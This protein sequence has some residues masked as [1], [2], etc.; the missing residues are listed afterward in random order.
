VDDRHHLVGILTAELLQYKVAETLAAQ[1]WQSETQRAELLENN[2][3]DIQESAQF[4]QT[5]FDTFPL[6]VFWKDRS[7][8]FLGCNQ[9]FARHA[10]LN[11]V[12]EILGQT[13]FDL[14][15][16]ETEAAAYRADDR[17]VI[18]SGIAKL[19]IIEI[20]TQADGTSIWIETNKLPL[21]N[22]QGETIGV[23]GTYQDITTRKHTETELQKLSER[24][25]LSLKSAAAGCWEW[26]IVNDCLLWD[27]RTYEVYGIDRPIPT[28]VG[29][30]V[31]LAEPR[32]WRYEVVG[33][34]AALAEVASP[35]ENRLLTYATWIAC[36]H[37]EDRTS[38]ILR[39]RI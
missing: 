19:G 2:T 17:Q 12:A 26:D 33:G 15:W 30:L 39:E 11:S 24:L 7:S 22:I 5:V 34:A 1:L 25:S 20:Q 9:N 32:L 37:P 38:A 10:N 27:D 14:P 23:L 28:A 4:L 8:R 36:I 35:L 31:P 6:A 29:G 16:G 21:Q 3:L 18:D 13:D